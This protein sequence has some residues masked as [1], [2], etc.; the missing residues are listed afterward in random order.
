MVE[1]A[2]QLLMTCLFWLLRVGQPWSTMAAGENASLTS[3]RGSRQRQ[4]A[5]EPADPPRPPS[6]P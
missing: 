1:Q 4:E 2:Q 5:N 6:P 3:K